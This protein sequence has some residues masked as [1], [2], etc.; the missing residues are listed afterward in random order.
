MKH[1]T[2][3]LAFLMTLYSPVAAQDYDKGLAAYLNE[4]YA[5]AFKEWKPLAEQGL[6]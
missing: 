1:L 3:I 2:M 5:T 4:D 6:A